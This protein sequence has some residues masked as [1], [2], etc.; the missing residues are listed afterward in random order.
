[1]AT[2]SKVSSVSS[3]TYDPPP[4]PPPGRPP[5]P[6]G[7]GGCL[8][9][10]ASWERSTAPWRLKLDVLMPSILSTRVPAQGRCHRRTPHGQND[11][12][13]S[14]PR[15]PNGP[16]RRPDRRR[17][18]AGRLLRPRAGSDQPRPAGRL[19]HLRSS[20]LQPGHR[21][22]REP[23]R[24]DDAGHRGVPRGPGH[25]RSPV[26]RQGHP[27]AVAARLED[28]PSRCSWPTG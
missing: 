7:A 28:A 1:M 22:Q 10:W 20:R 15:R 12:H 17:R 26:H 27:R 14:S 3:T 11:P 21:V 9:F 4:G 5:A 2:A 8:A 16:P 23:H 24:R 6:A 19:R 13:G 25:H 18:R